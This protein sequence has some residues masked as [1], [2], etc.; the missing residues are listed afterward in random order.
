L[1]IS[2]ETMA[3]SV[4]Y[5]GAPPPTADIEK[6]NGAILCHYAELDRNLSTNSAAAIPALISARKTFGYNIWE[7]V[8]HAFN[9]DTGAA[10]N[11]GVACE[12]WSKTLAFFNRHL[13]KPV[14]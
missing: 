3:A 13:N 10:F 2:G 7:G 6:L 4:V 12:A 1:A 5:Y 8:G 14:E 11:E 9:N